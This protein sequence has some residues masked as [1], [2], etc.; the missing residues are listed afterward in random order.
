MFA[1]VALDVASGKRT[2]QTSCPVS[3]ASLGS[4]GPAVPVEVDGRTVWLCCAGCEPRLRS[5]IDRYLARLESAATRGM[6]R[7]PE[8]AVIDTGTKQ[9]VFV[10]TE[11][12]VFEGRVVTLGPRSGDHYPVL[13]GLVPGERVASAGAFL[14]DAET[15]LDPST[16]A[17][18]RSDR[19]IPASVPVTSQR[20]ELTASERR[21]DNRR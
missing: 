16:R 18:P 1:S 15:R 11:T 4:M 9:I 14:L 2:P 20:T 21:P 17:L 8:S 13:E 19:A 10:E 5:A 6:L 3:G 7:V 12:G